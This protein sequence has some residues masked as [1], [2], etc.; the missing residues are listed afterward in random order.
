MGE[1]FVVVF[2]I[3]SLLEGKMVKLQAKSSLRS[4]RVSI[5]RL[6]SFYGIDHR[7]ALEFCDLPLEVRK[8]KR[9][10]A[11]HCFKGIK[12]LIHYDI[13]VVVKGCVLVSDRMIMV[14]NCGHSE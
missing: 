8:K 13:G 7:G 2:I 9:F 1:S 12:S 3:V 5:I 11:L 14:N 4:Y 10:N 6:L